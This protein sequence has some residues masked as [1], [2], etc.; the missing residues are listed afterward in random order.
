MKN[1][2]REDLYLLSRHSEL[3]ENEVGK[4]LRENIYPDKHSW[5]TFV[6]LLLI[7]LGVGFTVSGIIFFFAYNWSSLHKFVKIGLVEG[8][9]LVAVSCLFFIKNSI[10]KNILLTFASVLVG[11]LYAVFGQ[12]YQTGANAYDFFLAWTVFVTLWMVISNFAPLWLF[13]LVLLNTTVTLYA[14]QV[15][16]DWSDLLVFTL[17]FALNAISLL[18]F[19][20]LAKYKPEI[21]VPKWF[22]QILALAA[23]TYATLAFCTGLYST[24]SP[25]FLILIPAILILYGLGIRHGLASKTLFYLA[26]IPFSLIVMGA[27]L[28]IKMSRAEVMFFFISV[29]IIGSV[30]GVIINLL[31]CQKKWSNEQ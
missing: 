26:A 1:I 12:I 11:V 8:V 29:F 10:I 24:H 3:S 7:T 9:L 17:L 20:G 2:Q 16:R 23:I 18:L 31:R 22:L 27:A 14:E 5:E 25:V 15:A 13:Y 21:N 4:V 6:K 19:T 30:T 28:L